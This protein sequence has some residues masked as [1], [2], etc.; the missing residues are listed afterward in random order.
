M[1]GPSTAIPVHPVLRWTLVAGALA[2]TAASLLILGT[3]AALFI[4]PG[5]VLAAV[6]A[7]RMISRPALVLAG[8]LLI[9]VNLDH[10]RMGGAG[11][12][13]DILL[14]AVLVYGLVVRAGL[15]RTERGWRTPAVSW[16]EKAF[17][18]YLG[19]TFLSVVLS[20]SPLESVKR[21]AREIEYLIIFAF[22]LHAALEAEDR[23]RIVKAIVWSSLVPCLLGF[24]GLAFD[25]PSLLG[26]MAPVGQE[27]FVARISSTLSH[28]VTLAL[29]LGVT[30][31]LSISLFLEG[32]LFRRRHLAILLAIQTA[33]LYLTYGRSGWIAVF[34]ALVALLWL[35]GRK[36]LVLLGIPVAVAA[37]LVFLPEF[38][39]RWTPALEAT[40]ENSMLWRVSLWLHALG[41]FTERPFFGSGPGTF[42][43]HVAFS[44]GYASHQTWIGL[45]VETGVFGA[46]AFLILLLTTLRSMWK[47]FQDRLPGRDPV[48]EAALA[49]WIGF[50]VASLASEPF[51][52]PS[53]VIYL[54]V[55][56]ALG[57]RG[58]IESQA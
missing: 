25:V 5:I 10:F 17:A 39:E 30:I 35:R 34:A 26:R 56:A 3:P 44:R 48:L 42:L 21:F 14:S 41:V 54:W 29:Y 57:L 32:K 45:L 36:K 51:G 2:V 38:R 23:N 8:F 31:T 20:V 50:T 47:A 24:A 58:R 53:V 37:L 1:T 19:F 27:R 9:A 11:V 33:A 18:V 52:L 49:S 28:P 15:R 46:L 55:L 16:I 4:L 7:P 43:E 40:Q 22:V 12:S 6:V 13:A